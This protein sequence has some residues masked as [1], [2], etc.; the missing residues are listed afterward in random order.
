MKEVKLFHGPNHPGMHGNFSVHLTVDGDTVKKAKPNPGMLH[1]GFEKLMER[2]LWMSNIALIPRV[3]VPEPDI[4]ETVYSMAVE[5]IEEL[6][7][8]ERA[9][10]LRVIILEL[11]RIAVHMMSIGGIGGPTGVYT[12]PNWALNERDMILDI[13]EKITGHRIYHMYIV[14]GGVRQDINEEILEFIENTINDI[15]SR[16]KDYYEIIFESPI[17]HKRLKG[18]APLTKEQALDWGVTGPGLRSTGV[19]YDVRKKFPYLVYDKLDFD[20]P[21]AEESDAYTRLY[22]K[23]L[24]VKQSIKIIRQVLSDIP[25]GKVRNKLMGTA[26]KW[27]IKEGEAYGKV[28]SSRGEFGYYIVSTG[29]RYPYRIQVRGASYPQ[30][31]YGIE[32]GLPGTRLEDVSIWLDT[33]GVCS[34]EVDR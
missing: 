19:K 5:K 34:P 23:Y 21:I 7:V 27:K 1:R 9:K 24:E 3:C 15:E 6:E 14:P 17:I 18:T 26:L 32:A 12:A 25:K 33:M 20:I 8:P 28:E 11:A 31:L 2:R 30:G 22:L 16:L 10:Y 13:F 29:G 4:N